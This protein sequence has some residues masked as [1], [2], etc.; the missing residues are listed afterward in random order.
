MRLTARTC[1]KRGCNKLVLAG[2][3]LCPECKY[4]N[5]NKSTEEE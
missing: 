2:R 4:P 3:R 5:R 1:A